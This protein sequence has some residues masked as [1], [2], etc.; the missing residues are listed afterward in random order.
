MTTDNFDVVV[1]GGGHAGVEAVHAA[2]RLGVNAALVT[3]DAATIAQMSCNPAIGGLAKG[4]IVREIDALGGLMGLVIDAAGIQFRMLNRSKGPAVWGPRAQADK[5]LY[6]QIMRTMLDDCE[7]LT[8]IEDTVGQL[9]VSNGKIKGVF[10]ESGRELKA[11]AVIL[12]TGTFL[13]GLMHTGPEQRPG[14]RWGEPAAQRLSDSMIKAGLHLERLKTGTPARIEADSIDYDRL[15]KQ[16]GDE[17]PTPFSF[18]T[19]AIEQE[20]INCWITYTNAQTHEIIRKNLDRAPLYTGQITSVG[21]RYC[22]S[23]ETKIVRFAD[24]SRHQLFLE[25]E[26]RDSNWIYVNGLSTSLPCDV[27]EQMLHSVTGLEQ[28]KILRFGYAIEYDYAPPLQ[29]RATLQSKQIEGLF[30]AGQINGTSGYEEAAGQGLLAGVNAAHLVRDKELVTLRRD[31]AYIGVMIDDLVTKG[32]DEPYRMFT[33]RAEHRL[34]L[35][36]DNADER[37]TPVGRSW[38]LVDDKR[39]KCFEARQKQIEQISRYIQQR[40]IQGKTLTQLLRR[41]NRDADWLWANDEEIADKGFDKRAAE[42]LINDVR[43]TGYIEKQKRLTERFIKAESMKLP[44]DFDYR[45]I[46]QLRHEAQA[47]FNQVQPQTLGQASR[48]VGISPADIMVLMIHLQ[49]KHSPLKHPRIP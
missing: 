31:Q 42:R 12:T 38:G 39:W 5:Q 49:Q 15:D 29:I 3:M 30:L 43:Y 20:Q 36:S 17:K 23:I 7:N 18:M 48:I 13:R 9:K 34:L 33:S 8:I 45:Q 2:A 21:P 44:R 40:K 11:A 35:R 28:A 41:Q 47:R 27:Q 25:P 22:P 32:V 10:C 6:Q 26:G 1:V 19:A 16:P 14:G 46:E 37:L 4:Q 24:K